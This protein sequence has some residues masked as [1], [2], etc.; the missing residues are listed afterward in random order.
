MPPLGFTAA[1]PRTTE[2]LALAERQPAGARHN[3]RHWLGWL[4]GCG[5]AHKEKGPSVGVPKPAAA[6]RWPPLDRFQ[7]DP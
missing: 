7:A 3:H 2:R 5:C 4:Q 6:L 1:L